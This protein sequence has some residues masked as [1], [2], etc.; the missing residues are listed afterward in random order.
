MDKRTLDT[1]KH[2]LIL[3]NRFTFWKKIHNLLAFILSLVSGNDENKATTFTC[4]PENILEQ[5]NKEI[6]SGIS[7]GPK[8]MHP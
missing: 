4:S 1:D 5:R 2:N 7:M 8:I 3:T 6:R